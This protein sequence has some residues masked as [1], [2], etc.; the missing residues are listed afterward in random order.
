MR[1][2]ELVTKS[3]LVGYFLKFSL[4]EAFPLL[5]IGVTYFIY[6]VGATLLFTLFDYEKQED[7]EP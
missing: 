1:L 5:I 7:D 3:L 4:Y 2:L 6:T